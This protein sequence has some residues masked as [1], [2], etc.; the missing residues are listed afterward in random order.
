MERGSA[1][2]LLAD[3]YLGKG[4]KTNGARR[5]TDYSAAGGR[6][7]ET[8]K[9]LATLQEEAGQPEGSHQDARAARSISIPW[10]KSFIASSA[11]CIWRKT[12][13]RR[14]PRVQLP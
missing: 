10:E 14:D 4:D 8:L 2:E 13:R 1:Y 9:K 11:T 7:P 5:S 12:L 6:T 3:A